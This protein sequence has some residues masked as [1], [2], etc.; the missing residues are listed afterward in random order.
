[1][2]IE[3]DGALKVPQVFIKYKQPLVLQ[4]TCL[5]VPTLF[6]PS[7]LTSNVGIHL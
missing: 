5:S 2:R 6:S 1:M 4:A 7:F 3:R